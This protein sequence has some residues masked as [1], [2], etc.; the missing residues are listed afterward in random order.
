MTHSLDPISLSALLS[1]RVCHDLINPVG[2]IG[3]GLEVMD[4]PTM[5]AGMHDAAIDLVRSGA[6]KAIALLTYARLAYGAAGGSGAE[7]KLEDAQNVLVKIFEF[8]KAELDWRVEPALARK[9]RV[10]ALLILVHAATDCVPRGGRISVTGD[11]AGYRIV[12]EGDRLFLNDEFVATLEGDADDLK[13]K[14]TPAYIAG[15]L[16]RAE[17]GSVSAVRK[18]DEIVLAVVF[19]DQEKVNVNVELTDRAQTV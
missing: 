11:G 7:I 5:D 17:G 13:P 18:N 12:V 2:A 15:V 16:M 9:N 4:D 8:T 10:K 3:S 6:G 19:G 1:S 14:F